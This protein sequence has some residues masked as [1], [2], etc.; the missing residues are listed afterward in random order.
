MALLN[1]KI[2]NLLVVLLIFSLTGFT[3]VFISGY[4]LEGLNLKKWSPGYLLGILFIITPIYQVLL[5]AYAAIF[6]KFRYF[7]DRQIK[8]LRMIR[9]AFGSKQ[10]DQ[11]R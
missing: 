10:G 1:H 7:L 11:D 3:S 5:L 8:I 4:I 9:R 6:G 2:I